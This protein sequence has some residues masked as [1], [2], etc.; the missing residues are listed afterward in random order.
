MIK[1]I[2]LCMAFV[3]WSGAA[4]ALNFTNNVDKRIYIRV[5]YHNEHYQLSLDPGQS[6]NFFLERLLEIVKEEDKK[7]DLLF[8]VRTAE[9][10]PGENC[11]TLTIDPKDD[12]TPQTQQKITVTQQGSKLVCS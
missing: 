3:L 1:K 7:Q 5:D 6:D 11:T 4:D 10:G 12:V 9:T 8:T 2:G